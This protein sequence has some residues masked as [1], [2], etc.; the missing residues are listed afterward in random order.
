MYLCKVLFFYINRTSW[1]V[2]ELLLYT[3]ILFLEVMFYLASALAL[4]LI[5]S[6]MYKLYGQKFKKRTLNINCYF[7]AWM[8]VFLTHVFMLHYYNLFHKVIKW[9]LFWER[10]YWLSKWKS[11]LYI[12][13]F[14][15]LVR[16]AKYKILKFHGT[17]F[18]Y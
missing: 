18:L 11:L 4:V 3:F 6:Q 9:V 14:I 15:M 5:G 16:S 7:L 8:A 13:F 10:L 1:Y 12:F 17:N 2:I